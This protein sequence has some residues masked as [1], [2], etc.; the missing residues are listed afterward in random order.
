MTEQEDGKSHGPP[1]SLP[2]SHTELC[3]LEQMMYYFCASV[4]LEGCCKAWMSYHGSGRRI[5]SA[6]HAAS[7]QQGLAA[8]ITIIMIIM[9]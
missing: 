6:W 5:N 4:S 7:S 8:I 9:P 3:D 1:G 2:A